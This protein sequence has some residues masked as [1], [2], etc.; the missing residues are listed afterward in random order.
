MQRHAFYILPTEGIYVS[1][2]FLEETVIISQ[3][4]SNL[5]VFVTQT[6]SVHC[7]VRTGSWSVCQVHLSLQRANTNTKRIPW[8][9]IY[10][11]S[12]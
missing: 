9:R 6:E 12:M 2:W 7:V 5:S 8:I 3:Y 1:V 4:N 10:Y 11:G